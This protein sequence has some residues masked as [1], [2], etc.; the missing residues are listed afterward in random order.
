MGMSL[1]L[2]KRSIM[3]STFIS[4]FDPLGESGSLDS[5]LCVLV[6]LVVELAGD[7]AP[8]AVGFQSLGDPERADAAEGSSLQH[9]FGL[10]GGDDGAQ[11]LEHLGLGGHG[12]EHAPALRMRTLGRRAMIFGLQPIAGALDLSQDAAL[13][14]FFLEKT[15]KVHRKVSGLRKLSRASDFHVFPET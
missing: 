15:A 14:F 9:Q 7:D 2:K 1:S 11:E 10:D 12:I 13:L 3:P 6:Y 5:R 8:A 4:R